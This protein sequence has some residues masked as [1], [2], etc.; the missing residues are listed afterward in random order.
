MK[1]RMLLFAARMIAVA[2]PGCAGGAEEGGKRVEQPVAVTIMESRGPQSAASRSRL[3]EDSTNAATSSHAA[4]AAQS[5]SDEALI[6]PL[7]NP[8]S[9]DADQALAGPMPLFGAVVLQRTGDFERW[10]AAF[11]ESREQ[12]R[13]AGFAAQGLMRGVDDPQLVAVW[14]A[15]TD[16]QLA[17]R[18]F[19]DKTIWRQLRAAGAQGPAE[20]RLSANVAAKMEPG[21]TDL[22]AALVQLR[23]SDVEAFK[24]SFAAQEQARET[25][26]IVGYSLGQDVDDEH[27][28]HVYLQSEDSEVLKAYLASKQT[29]QN[30]VDAGLRGHPRVVFVKEGELTLCRQ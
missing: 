9:V 30:W 16:V 6:K 2:H 21:R 20:V 15:V 26:G 17:K 23:L 4:A 11:E 14:L 25:A 28:L 29:R 3:W 5:V 10:S 7:D 18:Y 24:T 8:Y 19:A 1:I 22:Y 13:A 27:L 12:R